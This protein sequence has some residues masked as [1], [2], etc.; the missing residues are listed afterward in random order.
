ME[1]CRYCVESEAIECVTPDNGLNMGGD[2][3]QAIDYLRKK[4]AALAAKR[5]DRVAREGKLRYPIIAVNDALT[6]HMFDN[7][8]GTGQSTMDGVMRSTNKIIAGSNFVIA[9]YGWCGRGLAMRAK[10]M[11]GKVIIIEIDPLK[12]IEGEILTRFMRSWRRPATGEIG[13][14]LGQLVLIELP[15]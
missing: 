6:K 9:G 10:G 3:Q 1:S 2:M 7:R 13:D 15:A 5:A 4:G 11:G 12:A 8:Y 14:F